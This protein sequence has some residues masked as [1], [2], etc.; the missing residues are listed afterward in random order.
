MSLDLDRT[1]S[2]AAL[3][4][5]AFV[6]VASAH[7]QPSAGVKPPAAASAAQHKGMHGTAAKGSEQHHSQMHDKMQGDKMHGDRMHGGKSHG[8]KDD[9][10]CMGMMDKHDKMAAHHDKTAAADDKAANCDMMKKKP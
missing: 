7:G 10:A 2:Y 9:K 3:A 4:A 8:G 5:A 6:F 1:L